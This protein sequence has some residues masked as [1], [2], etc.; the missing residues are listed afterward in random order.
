MTGRVFAVVGPSGVG[1]DTLLAGAV[2]AS[3]SLHWARRTITRP[4]SPGTE[5]YEGVSADEF[6]FLSGAGVFALEWGAHGLRY[7]IRAVEF[8]GLAQGLDV[9]FNGSRAAIPAAFARF[10]GLTVLRISAPS[11]VLAERLAA[12]GRE[13]A[14]EI[15]TRLARASYDVPEGP[16]II[17]IANDASPEI[18]VR[19]VLAAIQARG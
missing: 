14:S 1:K 19:R 17:D 4:D 11:K 7:G 9:V 3:P 5:P 13:T 16:P 2:A 8:D 10:A 18:G 6:T 15:E 12:R